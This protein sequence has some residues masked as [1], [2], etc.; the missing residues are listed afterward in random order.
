MGIYKKTLS[1]RNLS[2][3]AVWYRYI[4]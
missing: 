2:L 3:K 1:D 4:L